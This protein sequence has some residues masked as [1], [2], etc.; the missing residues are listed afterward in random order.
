MRAES[1]GAQSA[2]ARRARGRAPATHGL[3]HCL[4]EAPPHDI[5][6]LGGEGKAQEVGEVERCEVR[7]E[8]QEE[9]RRGGEEEDNEG[10]R[11][12]M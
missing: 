3:P 10:E 1:A 2:W 12:A 5:V 8:G 6:H 7:E 11:W 4:E 9:R